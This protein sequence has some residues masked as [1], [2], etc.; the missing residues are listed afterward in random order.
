MPRLNVFLDRYGSYQPVGSLDVGN[1][2]SGTPSTLSSFAYAGSYLASS[3]ARPISLSLPLQDQPFTPRETRAFFDGLLPE[4]RARAP[5]VKALHSS[6]EDYPSILACLNDETSGALVFSERESIPA[7]EARYAP[8]DPKLLREFAAQ[9]R[10]VALEMGMRTRLSLA[11]AESKLG[12]YH[13]GS[14]L[15]SGW[16]LPLGTAPSTHIVKASDGTFKNQTINE[17]LCMLAAKHCGFDV[18]DCQLL[19]AGGAEPLL[20]VTRFDRE[21]PEEALRIGDNAVPRRL[22][23]EDFCQASGLAG[24]MKY[25]PTHGNYLNRCGAIISRA[26]A[27]PFGDRV[28]FLQRIYFD[29]LIGNCDNHL[30]NH[31]LLWDASLDRCFVAPLYDVTCT[32]VYEHLEREMGVSLCESRKIDDVTRSEL[33]SAA[34]ELGVQPDI[35]RNLLDELKDKIVPALSQAE[36]DLEYFNLPQIERVC[37]EIHADVLTRLSK[38]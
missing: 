6:G 27:N 16:F 23:Q 18:A 11:G 15:Q 19:P 13:A 5:F 4:A 1:M 21:I 34:K 8:V 14:D 30:K 33:L 10:N 35:A 28:G 12:L 20:I 2:D 17:A 32:T 37:A 29:Y 31:A 3:N 9:P 26:S 7:A 22:H 38:A 36:K 25:E 24:E